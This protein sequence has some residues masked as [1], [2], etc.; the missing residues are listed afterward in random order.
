MN[1]LTKK[2]VRVGRA[3]SENPS[4]LP[5]VPDNFVM[6]RLRDRLRNRAIQSESKARA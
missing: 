5:Q 2:I 1:S 3:A 6:P 4:F